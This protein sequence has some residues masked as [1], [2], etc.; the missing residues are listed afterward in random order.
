MPHWASLFPCSCNNTFLLPLSTSQ[1]SSTTLHTLNFDCI[2][3]SQ[4]HFSIPSFKQLMHSLAF[5]TFSFFVASSV[6]ALSTSSWLPYSNLYSH[7][8]HF[9]FISHALIHHIKKLCTSF[10]ISSFLS[11][12]L[13]SWVWNKPNISPGSRTLCVGPWSMW[14]CEVLSMV[15]Q[16]LVRDA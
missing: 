3:T 6:S 13:P 12:T 8:S 7:T 9:S 10:S 1:S 14:Y 5:L 2:T 4:P 15:L 16:Y 11:T